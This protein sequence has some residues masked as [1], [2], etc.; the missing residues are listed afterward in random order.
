MGNTLSTIVIEISENDSN[1][2]L[3]DKTQA[4]VLLS[5]TCVDSDIIFVGDKES[6]IAALVK[7]IKLRS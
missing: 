4:V 3:W 5:M 6:T 2:K 7:I 1:Y